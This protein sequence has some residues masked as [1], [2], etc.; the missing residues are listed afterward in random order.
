MDFSGS[1]ISF[2]TEQGTCT[3]AEEILGLSEVE[4]D[5]VDDGLTGAWFEAE[6]DERRGGKGDGDAVEDAHS[7]EDGRNLERKDK[8]K[9]FGENYQCQARRPSSRSR[10]ALLS[11]L[12]VWL[13]AVWVVQCAASIDRMK[14]VTAAGVNFSCLIVL[15]TG[16]AQS[17][18]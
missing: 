10:G 12:R 13:R 18:A 1:K 4:E 5:E 7:R 2:L 14:L 17:K 3:L 9:G 6:D 16:A 8:D 15:G 11:R